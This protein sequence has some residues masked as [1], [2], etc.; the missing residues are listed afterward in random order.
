MNFAITESFNIKLPAY[1]L[2]QWLPLLNS[3]V[4]STE[5]IMLFGI[6]INYA[7]D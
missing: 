5:N 3:T 7:S 2:N 6:F 4:I 1:H